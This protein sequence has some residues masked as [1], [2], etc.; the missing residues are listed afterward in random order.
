VVKLVLLGTGT[1]APQAQRASAGLAVEHAGRVY[2]FD[3]GRGVVGRMAQAG[4]D[5]LTLPVVH[6]THVHPDHCCDLVPLLFALNYAPDPPREQPF[7]LI[8]PEGILALLGH[9]QAAWPWLTPRYPLQV[10]EIAQET[11]EDGDAVLASMPLAHGD[12]ANLG[13]RIDIGG[14]SVAYTGDTG[15]TPALLSLARDVD[16]LVAECSLPD[17]M[18]VDS[19]LSPSRLGPAAEAAGCGTLVVTH[20]Y[21]ENDPSTV[22]RVLKRHYGGRV[23][24]AED[25]QEIEV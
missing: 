23:I 25:L 21:P 8:G 17:A 9:L 18:A 7:T 4:I 5:L 24:L 20:L 15:P 10:R 6:L 13:Y 22:E 14:R 12:L 2:P 3:L 16:I 19:H 11:W 1:L